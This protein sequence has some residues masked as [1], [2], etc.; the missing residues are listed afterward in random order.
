MINIANET[1]LS[2]KEAVQY[3]PHRRGKR[4]SAV[5]PWRWAK[6]GARG[7]VL[8]TLATPGGMFTSVEALA[9]FFTALAEVD[10]D[11]QP[12]PKPPPKPDEK[13]RAASIAWAKRTLDEAG[14]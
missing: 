2:M 9:R 1:L 11:G 6:Y 13:A 4:V 5:T 3:I 10:R 8:E 14:I 12:R 7:V